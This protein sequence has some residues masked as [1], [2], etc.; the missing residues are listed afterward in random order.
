M[1]PPDVWLWPPQAIYPLYLIIG[2]HSG[3][4]C[5]Y[6]RRRVIFQPRLAKEQRTTDGPTLQCRPA[7]L[8]TAGNAICTHVW[9]VAGSR[10]TAGRRAYKLL[11]LESL[12][13]QRQSAL[14][15]VHF[16]Y[17]QFYKIISVQ[18]APALE[19]WALTERGT[20]ADP[21]SIARIGSL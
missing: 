18:H 1:L 8:P 9:R 4:R 11:Q 21:A 12:H 17:S 15:R 5:V 16:S 20:L 7:Q 3:C 6:Q 19:T 13:I 2:C 10:L 14:T